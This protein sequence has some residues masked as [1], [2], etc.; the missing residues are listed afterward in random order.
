[1]QACMISTVHYVFDTRVFHRECKSLAQAG[2]NVH[3]ICQ[4][5]KVEDVV[6][7][8]HIIGLPVCK[9]R[10]AR[11]RNGWRAFRM[12]LAQ[13]ADI[14][15]F[16]DPELIPWG[17]AL[18]LLTRKPVVY[19]I[20]EYYPDAI[21]TKRWLPTNVRTMTAH[22]FDKGERI[23]GRFMDALVVADESIA[24]RFPH[25]PNP[26][27][28]VYNFPRRD[29]FHQPGTK[30]KKDTRDHD[31]QLVYLGGI[32]ASRGLW[33]MLDMV[34]ILALRHG[35]DVGLWLAGPFGYADEQRQFERQV[36]TD[37]QLRARVRWLGRVARSDVPALLSQADIGLVPLQPTPKFEKNIPSKEFEYMA[38]GL[39]I[40]GSDLPPIRRFVETVGAGLL[41]I[42]D[43]AC[44]HA[45]QIAYLATHPAEAQRMG[46]NGRFAFETQYNWD[47]EAQKLLD[48]YRSLTK[49]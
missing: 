20:H 3:L 43:D 36:A 12:A 9:R 44:S 25:N 37:H 47:R 30:D 1:M 19:D 10:W 41:A 14:Y 15:H 16:H 33:M 46:D 35:L 38:C 5:D 45:A 40:V 39:P 42:P 34:R 26:V 6:D 13:R 48:L 49:A 2:I 31:V 32:T 18:R 22:V 7:S 8:V 28:V 29:E 4:H 21:S 23:A 17:L 24:D 11:I 27:T